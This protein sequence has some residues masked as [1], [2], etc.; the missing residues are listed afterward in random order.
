MS[1]AAAA[2]VAPVQ[3][4][5]FVCM[6]ST[7]G[8]WCFE[9]LPASAPGTVTNFLRYANAGSYSNQIIHRSVPNFVIQGGGFNISSSN[10]ISPTTTFAAITNEYAVPNTRGTVA[11]AKLGGDPNS[12]TSQ[13]FVNLA[14]NRSNLDNQN[15]GFTVF[16][17]VVQGMEVFDKIATLQVWNFSSLL[18]AFNELPLDTPPGTTT[19]NSLPRQY[20]VIVNRAYATDLLPGT[21]PEPYHC[22]TAIASETLSEVCS[23][24]V[25]F[26]VSVPGLGFYEATL[27]LISGS[28]QVVLAVKGLK[29]LSTTPAAFAAYDVNSKVLTVPSVRIGTKVYTS[30]SLKMTNDAL[31]QFTL[32][33]FTQQ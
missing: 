5:R 22:S 3:A 8:N 9:M 14:D 27:Q 30:L 28:P 20:V 10:E 33:S 18:G 26:P 15:G 13:W 23:G 31:Q 29:K 4:E 32:Q 2:M 16:A 7:Q 11:M 1:F 25:S 6:E 24:L 12:A 17:R 21:T 19:L